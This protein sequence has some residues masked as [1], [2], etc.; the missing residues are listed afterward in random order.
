MRRKYNPKKVCKQLGL[1]IRQMREARGWTL[2][3]C[4]ELGWPDWTHLQKIEAG[5]NIT[6]HTLVNLS[7][8]FGVSPGEF[9][10]V[11]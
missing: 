3:K 5:K 8:L 4:E 11:I 2:E 6:I 7:N 10:E 1:K 9:F